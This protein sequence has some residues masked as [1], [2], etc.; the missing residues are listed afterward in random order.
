VALTLEELT[1]WIAEAVS[2]LEQRLSPATAAQFLSEIGMPAAEVVS[3]A[4]TVVAAT[5]QVAAS[6]GAVG[7]QVPTLAA[8]IASQD[9]VSIGR[10][11]GEAN[12][13]VARLVTAVQALGS[14]VDG[15]ATSAG[16]GGPSVRG[17]A[18]EFA[19]R[20]FGF[21]FSAHLA[22]TAPTAHELAELLGLVE[23]TDVGPS[24]FVP[25]HLRRAV[26]F[27]RFGQLLQNPF[28][29]LADVYGWGTAAFGWDLFLRRLFHV[30]TATDFAFVERDSARGPAVLRIALVDIGPTE[31]PLPG[32]RARTR[33]AVSADSALQQALG[34]SVSWEVATSAELEASA[35]I[36]LR[37]PADLRVVQPG[38]ETGGE[39]K[40]G[41]TVEDPSGR[42][43]LLLG[44]AGGTRIEAKS[45]HVAAGSELGW[46]PATAEATGEFIASAS[47]TDGRLVLDF[48]DADGFLN[49]L[50]PEDGVS[51]DFDL[52]ILWSSSN[53]LHFEGGASL[54]VD[55]PADL[56]LGPVRIVSVHVGLEASP[57]GLTLQTLGSV[58]ARLGPFALAIDR[59]GGE[60]A[61]SFPDSGGNLGVADLSV[62]FR[63]PEGIGLSLDTSVVKGGG[64]LGINE[65]G[66]EYAGILELSIGPVSI[67]AIG[68]LTTEIP[69][70]AGWALLLLVFT[71]FSAVQ[72][73]F[74]FTLNGV[75]GVI[76][77]QHGIATSV[78]QSG[79]RTG[80]LDSVLFPR[81]P[82]A[83]APRLLNQLRAVFPITPRALTI[84][85]IL[86]IG[87][88]TPPII[89]ISLGIVLQFDDVLGA[90]DGEPQLTRIVLLG[91]L[92]IQVPPVLGSDVPPLLRLL[93]DIVGNFEVRERTL[94]IDARLRDSHVAGLPLTGSLVARARFGAEP[95]FILAVGGY[96]PRFT[97]LPPGLPAQE[98]V[99]FQL[100]YDI[101]TV[102]IIGYTAITSNTF[103]IGA[104]ASLLASGGGFRIEAHLGF[105]ALFLF[106][107]VFHFEID[108]RVVAS[109][110]YRSL[111]LMSLRVAG[112]LSGPG[113]WMVTGHASF[114]VLFWDVDIDF[115]VEW[116]DVP[117]FALPSIAIGPLLIA[118]LESADNWLAQ[119]PV[120]SEALVTLRQPITS[121]VLA[122]PL[123]QLSVLQRV[124]PLGIDIDR[125]GNSRPSDGNNFDITA[126]EI[127][128]PGSTGFRSE[129][130]SYRVEHFARGEYLDLPE[131]EKLST[132]SFERFRAGVSLSSDEYVTGGSQISYNPEFETIYLGQPEAR[133]HGIL[134][135]LIFNKLSRF[136][137]ASYSDLRAAGKLAAD[138][139]LLISVR[140]PVFTVAYADGLNELPGQVAGSQT[141][142]TQ[143]AKR[144][145]GETVAVEIAEL[146]SAP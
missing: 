96:H 103:Q 7:T 43:T 35:A 81:D 3:R 133:E 10:A 88:S 139:S 127:G 37:P 30:M 130:P 47:I 117:I 21:L 53:G 134:P 121:D 73:G 41:I 90:S 92:R 52:R 51:L 55:L 77:L 20:L 114:S 79:L 6:A 11:V 27:D 84:G 45:L 23:L 120:G 144:A 115:E 137:A 99:G 56:E 126:V 141:V 72:L 116:G 102:Q 59:I 111:S 68:I 109:V 44:T 24:G 12:P 140:A 50:L 28:D 128:T 93:V 94:S 42:P 19:G 9:V 136:G 31:D 67:K 63:P 4:P 34:G 39:V 82:V 57:A 25:A 86:K 123:G 33:A 124:V 91:Q 16:A 97:D 112:I 18:S 5:V 129:S 78:L 71:E 125:V 13:M 70:E 14:A 8:A 146:I 104:E 38:V 26:R 122:H 46:Q 60:T 113:H 80:V 65:E 132:P 74:G 107:P 87:W 100:V 108:F 106:Q 22:R 89:T 40:I 105:D 1:L 95:S 48:Q 2:P 85:P 131:E 66:T 118:A 119:L 61:L 138:K 36:E 76:G 142:V 143:A 49:A 29:V 64:F 62:R 145:E 69:G 58:I 15:V 110:K 32:L 75:G 98:R 135:D 17:F 83:N 101:V 54:E